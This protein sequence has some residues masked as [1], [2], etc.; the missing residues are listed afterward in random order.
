MGW[1]DE[2]FDQACIQLFRSASDEELAQELETRLQCT[3]NGGAELRS[4]SI[5]HAAAGSKGFNLIDYQPIPEILIGC[6]LAEW[7]IFE[8]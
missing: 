2:P 6:G 3:G 5:A 1:I 4:W 8:K 7:K